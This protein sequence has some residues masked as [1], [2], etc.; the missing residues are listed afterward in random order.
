MKPGGS[1]AW[2]CL[3]AIAAAKGDGVSNFDL[4]LNKAVGCPAAKNVAVATGALV[5]KQ[6]I[7]RAEGDDGGMLNFITEAGK[8]ALTA[9]EIPRAGAG[10][11]PPAAKKKPAKPA[12]KKAPQ[13]PHRTA[14][15][16]P[17]RDPSSARFWLSDEF[18]LR[19]DAD[20]CTGDLSPAQTQQLAEFIFRHFDNEVPE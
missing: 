19:V 17:A 14:R 6:L 5:K 8:A 9:G 15:A 2:R 18:G 13:K 7:G 20:A 12:S 1:V 3:V 16:A 4:A 11:A 10:K